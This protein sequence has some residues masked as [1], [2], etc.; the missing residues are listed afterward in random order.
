MARD[1]NDDERA[2]DEEEAAKYRRA[3]DE[4][5]GQLDWCVQYLYRIRKH[6]IAQAIDRNRT[7]IR[8]QMSGTPE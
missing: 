1:E 8:R 3:A 4:A 5:L 7:F 6:S 2:R